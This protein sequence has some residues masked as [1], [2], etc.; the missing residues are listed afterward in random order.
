MLQNLQSS[1]KI[2]AKL[3]L[4]NR[5]FLIQA[6]DAKLL[7]RQF[8]N[9][10]QVCKIGP[11]PVCVSTQWQNRDCDDV[12]P[13]RTPLEKLLI[14]SFP[15]IWLKL[16][17]S[18]SKYHS[19]DCKSVSSRITFRQKIWSATSVALQLSSAAS[20]ILR[21][22]LVCYHG[23]EIAVSEDCKDE[24]S[25]PFWLLVNPIHEQSLSVTLFFSLTP[26]HFGIHVS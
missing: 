25:A 5:N 13:W 15:E 22:I 19:G 8:L 24:D 23:F 14:K 21:P 6:V 16:T 1:V 20:F 7:W 18:I 17:E 4:Y 11:T 9:R 3:C 10:N 2:Y 12:K 26:E